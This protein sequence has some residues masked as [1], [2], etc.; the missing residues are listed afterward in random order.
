M[1]TAND[2]AVL[3]TIFNPS[4]PFGDIPGLDEEEE[5][6]DTQEEGEATLLP[7]GVLV[8]AASLAKG[9]PLRHH[10]GRLRT[11]AAGAGAGPGAAGGFCRRV[12]R[13][14]HSPGEVQR[15][16]PPAARA[17][18]GL[19]QPGPGAAPAGGRGR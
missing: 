18:L 12:G 14:E 13:R 15:G 7:R 2:R 8:L 11:G 9:S 16:H 6:E 17:R 5:E 3:Q 4:T 10:R 19:Q 1:A